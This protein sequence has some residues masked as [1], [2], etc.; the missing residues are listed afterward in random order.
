MPGKCHSTNRKEE[1]KEF[2][3]N[4]GRENL[5]SRLDS[6]LADISKCILPW[7]EK[8]PKQNKKNSMHDKRLT[9]NRE[10]WTCCC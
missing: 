1:S 3:V 2:R 6:L 9:I 10:M 4:S 8:G 7:C 5:W